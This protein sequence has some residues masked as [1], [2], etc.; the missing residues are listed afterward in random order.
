MTSEGN[1]LPRLFMFCDTFL[2]ILV[3]IFP[4]RASTVVTLSESSFYWAEKIAYNPKGHVFFY[5]V[6]LF[7]DKSL[8]KFI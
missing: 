1:N 2:T 3:L 8:I 7:I 5:P 6:D 4:L